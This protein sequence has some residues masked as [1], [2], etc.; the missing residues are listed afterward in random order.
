MSISDKNEIRDTYRLS[1]AITSND[2][3]GCLDYLSALY[4]KT[5]LPIIV[6]YYE[7]LKKRYEQ[8]KDR[9]DTQNSIIDEML[10]R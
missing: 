7:K 4:K 1:K 2:I 8:K 5:Q 9:E 6:L 10:T 3:E